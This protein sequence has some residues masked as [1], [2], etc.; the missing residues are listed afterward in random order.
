M[1]RNRCWPACLACRFI[2]WQPSI[3]NRW[4]RRSRTSGNLDPKTRLQIDKP[5]KSIIAYATLADHATI[6]AV[7]EKLD[8]TGRR[9]E[10][11][12][13]R[14]LDADYV[15][16]TIGFLITG[17]KEKK[18]ESRSPFFWGD[19]GGSRSEQKEEKPN[20]FRVD[21]DIQYNRLLLWANDVEIAEVQN[22][23][24]KLGEIPSEGKNTGTVRMLDVTPGRETD[25]W[26]ERVRE[27]W[28]SVGRNPLVLPPPEEPSKPAP[29][30]KDPP[31]PSTLPKTTSA[32]PW[33][34]YVQW[35]ELRAEAP[36]GAGLHGAK[37]T[38]SQPSP[39]AP[40]PSN[41]RGGA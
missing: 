32:E 16:G 31:K 29:P 39:P 1:I 36:A 18:K 9:F 7:V 11:I 3:P 15:A 6:R 13:L 33:E 14:R 40:L 35:A 37:V 5:N 12:P 23:L 38:G 41:E 19:S 8:G 24:V 21:A 17:G 22:L 27:A 4:S 34:P 10:V 28:P 25:E 30:A 26:L 20:E 2:G